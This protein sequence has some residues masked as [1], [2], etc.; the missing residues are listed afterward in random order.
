[1]TR[2]LL[3]FYNAQYS[4]LEGDLHPYQICDND[5]DGFDSVGGAFD[6]ILDTASA[7]G[8]RDG[9]RL[10]INFCRLLRRALIETVSVDVI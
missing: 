9:R 6:F 7:L 10:I 8:R 5:G 1:M 2:R 4:A 3:L